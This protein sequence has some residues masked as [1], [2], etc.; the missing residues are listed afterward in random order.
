M[1]K[2]SQPPLIKHQHHRVEIQPSTAHNYAKYFCLDC[3]V[4]VSWLSRQEALQAQQLGLLKN[5]QKTTI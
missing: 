4:F 2:K 5:V 3:G 1:K